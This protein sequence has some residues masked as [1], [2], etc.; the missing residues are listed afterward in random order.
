M[1][2]EGDF[3]NDVFIF[4]GISKVNGNLEAKQV[5]GDGIIIVNKNLTAS[6]INVDGILK[7]KGDI[8][9]ENLHIDGILKAANIKGENLNIDG[10]VKVL[11]NVNC[12]NLQ[13]N[14]SYGCLISSIEGSKV[15][16]NLQGKK[17]CY[18]K[19]N[20]ISAD[21]IDI[22]NVICETVSG[23]KVKIGKGCKVN[24]VNY[25]TQIEIDE[26]AEVKSSEKISRGD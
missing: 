1:K 10:K 9:A 22:K 20:S 13:L 8:E 23:D 16:V 21:E 17:R 4:D 25:I 11:G 3:F 12:D 18:L 7:V 6:T 19:V 5:K 14:I 26:D 2:N 15:T 24:H